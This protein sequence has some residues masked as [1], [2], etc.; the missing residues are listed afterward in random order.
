MFRGRFA[1]L[2]FV[3]IRGRSAAYPD[4]SLGFHFII[5]SQFPENAHRV[6]SRLGFL[7]F[8]G[9]PCQPARLIFSSFKNNQLL[10]G[11]SLLTEIEPSLSVNTSR[12][13]E[14]L[15]SVVLATI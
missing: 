9:W 8:D 13:F 1:S 14:I 2:W 15:S 4:Q 12:I 3:D 7:R 10:I 6:L 5:V 11:C